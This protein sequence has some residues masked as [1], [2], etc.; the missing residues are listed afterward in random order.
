M[1]A[2]RSHIELTF[3]EPEDRTRAN[4]ILDVRG[5]HFHGF[6]QAR[7]A[8]GDPNVPAIGE[9]LAAACPLRALPHAARSSR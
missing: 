6:R 3:S 2:V 5:D 1:T 7:R 9:E 8:S 4:A